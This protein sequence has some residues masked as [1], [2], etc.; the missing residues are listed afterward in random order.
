VPLPLP[1]ESGQALLV[2]L[3]GRGLYL[4]TVIAG[5]AVER[6]LL[7]RQPTAVPLGG[8]EDTGSR[9]SAPVAAA[10][11]PP[12]S[13]SPAA[14]EL[15]TMGAA[16]FLTAVVTRVEHRR[17]HRS[18]AL[19]SR[20]LSAMTIFVWRRGPAGPGPHR[21]RRRRGGFCLR[22][23]GPVRGPQPSPVR[24][25][26]R[27]DACRTGRGLFLAPPFSGFV[28]VPVDLAEG[29]LDALATF[30]VSDRTRTITSA[31]EGVTGYLF[32]EG[33]GLPRTGS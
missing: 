32:A 17:A 27:R 13:T 8:G 3:R 1:G 31:I 23:R 6:T 22:S 12:S 20:P 28:G 21:R 9:P 24:C 18:C 15:M 29:A 16:T 7:G 14:R 10:A 26:L 4:G 5:E 11:T 2:A 33:V 19:Y 30:D 25:R